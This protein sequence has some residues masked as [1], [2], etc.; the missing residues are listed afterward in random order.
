MRLEQPSSDTAR[1]HFRCSDE[2][3]WA[4]NYFFC[5]IGIKQKVFTTN[6]EAKTHLASNAILNFM[7]FVYENLNMP[8]ITN[9]ETLKNYRMFVQT[10]EGNAQRYI[11][12]LSSNVIIW[13]MSSAVEKLS[14]LTTRLCTTD[15]LIPRI[16]ILNCLCFISDLPQGIRTSCKVD[17]DRNIKYLDDQLEAIRQFKEELD[18]VDI[19]TLN[20]FEELVNIGITSRVLE[21]LTDIQRDLLLTAVSNDEI[22]YKMDIGAFKWK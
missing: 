21:K 10:A 20:D 6:K 9:I 14:A 5:K 12:Y 11:L 13:L 19:S 16:S 17:S 3:K 1:F 15:S 18:K 2:T 22:E 7:P 8:E 4:I